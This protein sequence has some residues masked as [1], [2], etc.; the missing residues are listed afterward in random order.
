VSISLLSGCLG[1]LR[2]SGVRAVL[3]KAVGCVC[4]CIC[5]FVREAG[6]PSGACSM[7]LCSMV[8]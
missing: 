5:T 1:I 6:S 4:M 3:P 7:G 8:R 2:P